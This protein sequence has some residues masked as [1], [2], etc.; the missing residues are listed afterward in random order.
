MRPRHRRF[1]VVVS[2]AKP[3]TF[4]VASAEPIASADVI[5][6][7]ILADKFPR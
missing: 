4:G 5:L 6:A 2:H 1:V 3:L 7:K